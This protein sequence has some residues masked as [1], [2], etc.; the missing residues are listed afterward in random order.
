M[1]TLFNI[2]V[3]RAGNELPIPSTR[4]RILRLV[5]PATLWHQR[6]LT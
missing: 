4:R 6:L 1:R 5:L 3:P 2:A